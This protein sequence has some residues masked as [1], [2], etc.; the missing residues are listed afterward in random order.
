MGWALSFEW[1]S[2]E[3][4][5]GFLALAKFLREHGR[6]MFHASLQPMDKQDLISAFFIQKDHESHLWMME[7][8]DRIISPLQDEIRRLGERI[9]QLEGGPGEPHAD[10]K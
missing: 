4:K 7:M 1:E 3:Q 6:N 2:E 8:L 5:K 10:Q 9:R